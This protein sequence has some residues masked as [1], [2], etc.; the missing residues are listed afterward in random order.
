MRH[1]VV[2]ALLLPLT[3]RVASQKQNADSLVN[4][5]ETKRLTASERLDIYSHLCAFYVESDNEKI[6]KY[7]GEG[8]TLAGKEKDRERASFFSY[9]LG[10]AY[11]SQSSYDTSF[12][13]LQKALDLAI[14]TNDQAQEG[15]IY[16]SLGNLYRRQT[17]Y[18]EA[19]N[20]YIKNKDIAERLNN[21]NSYAISLVNIGAVYRLTGNIEKSISYLEQAEEISRDLND[22]YLQMNVCYNIGMNYTNIK[23]FEKALEYAQKTKELSIIEGEKKFE[24]AALYLLASVYNELNDLDNAFACASQCVQLAEEYGDQRLLMGTLIGMGDIYISQKKYNDSKILSLKAWNIDSTDLVYAKDASYN[25]IVSNIY[26]GDKEQANYFLSKYNEIITMRNEKQYHDALA[27]M[28]VKYETEKKE[29]RISS[30]EKERRMYVWLGVTGVLLAVALWV[31]YWQKLRNARRQH[32]LIAAESLQ[33]GEIGERARIAEDLHDRLGGSLSAVKI[34][35]KNAENL[36]IISDKIDSCMREVS[37]ITNNIMPRTLRLFGLKAA[38]EDLSV[39]CLNVQFH[40]FGEDRRIKYNLEYAVYCCARELVNNA[41]KHSG[42]EQINVQ[43]VQDRKNI[44]LTVQDD[45]RGFDE[46]TVAKGDGLQNIRNR[47]ASCKGKLDI[48]SSPDRGTE[49]VIELRVE[50]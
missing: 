1:L 19:I 17:N 35:L 25:L 3:I 31:I 50:T 2:I 48:F 30:L 34:E 26:L 5:L 46:K 6:I 7:A 28:E 10:I 20:Y 40:F 13:Y 11:Y 23:Q 27:D 21:K 49:A 15:L 22:I 36:Q 47:I 44:S 38:L 4:I 18:E 45:G 43:L 24:I 29:A 39:Q 33:E 32:Q 41:L 37:E 16:T 12:M 14:E 42:A 9:Q 8:L